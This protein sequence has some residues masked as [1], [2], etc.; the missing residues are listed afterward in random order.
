MHLAFIKFRYD[1]LK[2]GIGFAEFSLKMHKLDSKP[3][4]PVFGPGMRIT[5][6]VCHTLTTHV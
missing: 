6:P 1:D 2:F 4:S 3:F 5:S